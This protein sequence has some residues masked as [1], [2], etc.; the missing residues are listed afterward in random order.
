MDFLD[1]AGVAG[2]RGLGTGDGTCAAVLFSG[3]VLGDGLL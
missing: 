2:I 3:R 1:G